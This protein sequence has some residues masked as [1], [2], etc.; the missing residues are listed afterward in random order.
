MRKI[1]STIANMQQSARFQQFKN[2]LK[3]FW[4]QSSAWILGPICVGLIAVGLA[5][6]SE[7]ANN[8]NQSLVRAFPLAPLVFMPAGFA[9]LAYLGQRFVAGSQGSGIPQ[10]IAA[11]NTTNGD[12]TNHLLSIRIAIGKSLL[13]L[14]GL[15]IGASIGREGPT[16]QIGASIMNS[17]HGRWFLQ[18]EKSRRNLIL[19]G[20]AAGIAAAFNAPLAGIMFAIEELNKKYTLSGNS[21]TLATV[22]LSGFISLVLLGNYTYFGSTDVSL[23]WRT[24]AGAIILCSVIGGI[25]GGIFSR[26]MIATA[27]HM[28]KPVEAFI[29]KRGLWFAAGCGL[30]L[31]I[32]GLATDG[33]IFGAGYH[34]TRMTLEST[35]ALPWYFGIAKFTATLVS[36][37]SGIAGGIF[38]PSLAVG[39]GI[40]DNLS[41]LLPNLAPHSAVVLLMMAA[42]LSAVTRDPM[43]SFI[44]MMEMTG[45]HQMLLPLMTV[46]VAAST[47]SKFISPAPLYQKMS[48]KFMGLTEPTPTTPVRLTNAR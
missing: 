47:M 5:C 8:I 31:A 21:K 37:A 9:L 48:E 6:G 14:G 15:S 25:A 28:P 27:F 2:R 42:Y 45:S 16:V 34:P 35:N 36:S 4:H 46:S 33:A 41:T 32:I 1:A 20:A 26:L 24:S 12:K 3:G 19:A 43:T 38:A 7:W 17:F 13:M 11:I 23:D 10:T 18:G 40:G 44:I 22:I 39:A 30:I 29:Q